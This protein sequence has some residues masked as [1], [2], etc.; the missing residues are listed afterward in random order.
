MQRAAGRQVVSFGLPV[1]LGETHVQRKL[2]CAV[3]RDAYVWSTVGLRLGKA[4]GYINL[5][6]GEMHMS[7]GGEQFMCLQWK[8]FRCA[9][10]APTI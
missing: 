5:R 3:C 7:V 9:F 6:V 4:R 10:A 2:D 1:M 8:D